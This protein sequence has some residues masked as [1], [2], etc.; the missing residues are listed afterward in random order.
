MSKAF[1]MAAYTTNETVQTTMDGYLLMEGMPCEDGEP[2]ANCLTFALETGNGLYY[3]VT[4]NEQ[5]KNTLNALMMNELPRQ[6]TITGVPFKQG[7]VDYVNVYDL[8]IGAYRLRHLCDE[9][10]VLKFRYNWGAVPDEYRFVK[11]RLTTDTMIICPT[12]YTSPENYTYIKLEENGKYKGALREGTNR[13]IYYIPADSTNV[14][15]LYAFNAEVGDT[16]TNVWLGVSGSNMISVKTATIKEIKQTSPRIFVI[17]VEYW[18]NGISEISR[19]EIE[20]IEGVGCLASPDAEY[21]SSVVPGGF[22]SI[23]LCAYKDD[24]QV[25][26]SELAEEYGCEFKNDSTHS[27]PLYIKDGPGSSTVEPVDPNQIRATL[28]YDLLTI[29]EFMNKE[30]IYQLYQV[31]LPNK[32]PVKNAVTTSQTFVDSVS[33]QLTEP[34]TY[35]LQ[36]TNPEW[37]YV[38]VGT[39]DYLSDTMSLEQIDSPAHSVRKILRNGQLLFMRD[40]NIYTITG[41][42]IR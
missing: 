23:L 31:A 32:M 1:C 34:G 29:V 28:R 41:M 22:S 40:G 7:S 12:C 18:S 37:D 19:T 36:L 11:Y 16:L 2:C 39:F 9:W 35:T 3:L 25:Y 17:D 14:Y 38:I 30:I 15:L 27:I 42:Q 4:E 20:W 21:F 24:E 6:A 10:N 8:T 33:I 5:I 26:T 13:D